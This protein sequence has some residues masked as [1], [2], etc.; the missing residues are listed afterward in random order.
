MRLLNDHVIEV[1]TYTSVTKKIPSRNKEGIVVMEARMT[2]NRY[3]C[4][5]SE[6]FKRDGSVYNN[7]MYI[8]DKTSGQSYLIDG[9]YD[10][11]NEL[12]FGEERTIVK[13]FEKN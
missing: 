3:G 9:N 6:A 1:T 8:Y 12:I 2:F 13:G 11:A 4:Y 5:T 7:K 10:K